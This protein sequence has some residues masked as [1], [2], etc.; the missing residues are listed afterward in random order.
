MLRY[1]LRSSSSHHETEITRLNNE[2]EEYRVSLSESKEEG[3]SLRQALE[4]A[5]VEYQRLEDELEL[6]KQEKELMIE[7][8]RGVNKSSLESQKLTESEVR[9]Y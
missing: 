1:Q 3:L 9:S 7:Q 8:I 2:L 6:L 5:R 4:A